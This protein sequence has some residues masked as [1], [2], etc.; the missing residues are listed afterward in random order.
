M[1]DMSNLEAQPVE[2]ECEGHPAESEIQILTPRDVPLGGPRA[3]R[4]RRTLPQRER[5]LIGGW[6]FADHYG[7][8]D[9]GSGPGMHVRRIRIP[10]CRR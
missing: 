4:V 6:C 1:D 3:M 7:P 9:V 10:V 2:Q 8:D 5:S